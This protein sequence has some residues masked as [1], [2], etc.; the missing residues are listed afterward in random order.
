MQRFSTTQRLL[1]LVS[2]LSTTLTVTTALQAADEFPY[3][4][5]VRFEN[6]YLRSGPA[7]KFY[8]TSEIAEGGEVEVYRH[9]KEWCA[10]RPPAGS[11]CWVPASQIASTPKV[12]VGKVS[13]KQAVAWIGSDLRRV[14]EHVWHVALQPGELVR[15]IGEKQVTNASGGKE[16][17][18]KIAPPRGDFRWISRDFI[19][20]LS[21]L[22]SKL[23]PR[24]SLTGTAPQL[25]GEGP[26]A[27]PP[28]SPDSHSDDVSENTTKLT[29]HEKAAEENKEPDDGFVARAPKAN[30]D[31]NKTGQ[32]SEE[33]GAF[34]EVAR[35]MLPI[36]QTPAPGDNPANTSAGPLTEFDIELGK[37]D[38][39]LSLEVAKDISGWR[40]EATKEAVEEMVRSGETP[41]QRG[42]ARL[43]LER[44]DSFVALQKQAQE[45][46][47]GT[48]ALSGAPGNV[49]NTN[50]QS[51][52]AVNSPVVSPNYTP[53]V[54]T[55]YDGE[56]VL[57]P[58]VSSRRDTPSYALM[59][60]EGKILHYVTP[61]PGINV[62]RYAK[63]KIGVFGRRGFL[64]HLQ[65]SHVTAHRIVVLTK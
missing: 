44:I 3:R 10:V 41:I 23:P 55:I 64:P 43:L 24:A 62:H 49:P 34:T 51:D 7:D 32:P 4:A 11:F 42:R 31:E 61:A 58:V 5:K 14:E 37:H 33:P 8:P 9:D 6:A 45:V 50:G 59:S 19:T 63:Q 47:N 26:I 13:S 16:T 27:P 1:L 52:T 29:A 46:K 22:E 40:L 30:D 20:P 2:I 57:M 36:K 53:P 18:L 48:G 21:E 39:D 12:D 25:Q 17:W 28:I 38:T 15:L 54:G 56:G 60:S 65:A 35:G